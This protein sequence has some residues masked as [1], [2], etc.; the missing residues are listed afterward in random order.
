[1]K[2][3]DLRH[4]AVVTIQN[5]ERVGTVKDVLVDTEAQ[6]IAALQVEGAARTEPETIPIDRVRSIG[7]DAIMLEEAE[8]K[9]QPS[10]PGKTGPGEGVVRLD[11]LL[12][13]KVLSYEG[14]LLGTL[15]DLGFDTT[16]FQIT[17]YEVRPGGLVDITG[18]RKRL[19]ASPDIHF[20]KGIITVPEA[21]YG[22]PEEAEEAAE[23]RGEERARG[24]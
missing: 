1:M 20:G 11:E 10:R 7:K 24:R 13:G 9:A 6:R 5:A 12:G 17:D 8:A 18:R 15:V 14:N 2:A 4:K 21:A 16:T 23:T 19:G 3:T 22:A